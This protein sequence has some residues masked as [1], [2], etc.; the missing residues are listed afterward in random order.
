MFLIGGPLK[1]G[2]S[3]AVLGQFGLRFARCVSMSPDG[4]PNSRA[5]AGQP[6]GRLPR[7]G[8]SAEEGQP[9][10]AEN[11]GRFANEAAGA[12]VGGD[13]G[14]VA[15]GGFLRVPAHRPRRVSFLRRRR[16]HRGVHQRRMSSVPRF[17]IGKQRMRLF[18]TQALEQAQRRIG[19]PAGC[20][21]RRGPLG[22]DAQGH[23]RGKLL[24]GHL[25]GST[26]APFEDTLCL[27]RGP[28]GQDAQGHARGK[29]VGSPR[30]QHQRA[31][32][33]TRRSR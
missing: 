11:C 1:N 24:V 32:R 17:L 2:A 23:A 30:R 31:L 33:S 13:M 6:A 14:L 8:R 15:V 22:Q 20:L 29:R 19:R 28:L 18:D 9:R 27:R 26:S 10:R 21:P 25:A 4:C 5:V 7:A 3:E 16:P 12:L